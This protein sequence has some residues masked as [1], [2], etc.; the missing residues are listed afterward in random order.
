MAQEAGIERT[1][2]EEV[3]RE[4]RMEI[5]LHHERKRAR[6]LALKS[7]KWLVPI[8]FFW[9]LI[10]VNALHDSAWITIVLV[11]WL[12]STLWIGN[13]ALKILLLEK[14]IRKGNA[15]YPD[16]SPTEAAQIEAAPLQISSFHLY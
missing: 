8:Y 13:K 11:S 10:A 12:F 3:K 16:L 7:M 5:R 4:W 9:T 1:M 6:K 15:I 2:L 14:E